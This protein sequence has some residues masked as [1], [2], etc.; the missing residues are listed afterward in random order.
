MGDPSLRIALAQ[1]NVW[2]GDIEG[3]AR[4][5]LEAAESARDEHGADIVVFPEMALIGYPPDDLLLRRGL[6]MV[7]EASLERLRAQIQGITAVIGYP[8]YEGDA[9]YNS[10]LGCCATA[11]RSVIIASS[12]CP[13]TGCSMNV[14]IIGRVTPPACSSTTVRGSA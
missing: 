3:N 11:S 13:T 4:Q 8:E 12:A 10:A 9:I 6:P 5:I 7:I 2:V 1:L 14:G